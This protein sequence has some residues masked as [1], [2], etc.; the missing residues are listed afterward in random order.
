[1]GGGQGGWTGQ[2]EVSYSGQPAAVSSS[3]RHPQEL[4]GHTVAPE[5]RVTVV[6]ASLCLL[7]KSTRSSEI[8]SR[9]AKRY[10]PHLYRPRPPPL[11]V[12]RLGG[13][14]FI[15]LPLPQLLP[16]RPPREVVPLPGGPPKGSSLWYPSWCSPSKELE[17]PDFG[18]LWD[19]PG[20][21]RPLLPR[22]SEG[23]PGASISLCSEVP[24]PSCQGRFRGGRDAMSMPWREEERS[25]LAG[26]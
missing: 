20:P 12:P 11:E 21:P 24:G 7:G 13:P 4:Q 9:G 26:E 6:H 19:G 23:P 15:L 5:F 8:L 3:R 22:S 17:R 18:T 14:E 2:K 16:L 1:M 25:L 10:L